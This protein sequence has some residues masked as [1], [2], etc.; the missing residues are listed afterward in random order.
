MLA[1]EYLDGFS[2]NA[3][4]K[5]R[6]LLVQVF[7]FAV[8]KGLAE[9]NVAELTLVKQEAEKKRQRHTLEGLMK[10]V[11]AKTTPTDRYEQFALGWPACNV[12]RTSCPG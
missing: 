11:E 3:Y 4:T 9:R 5:H 10:I 6:G 8:A 12:G 7:S 2:N 1:E